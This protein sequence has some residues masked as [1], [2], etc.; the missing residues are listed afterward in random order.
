M[1]AAGRFDLD[2]LERPPLVGFLLGAGRRAMREEGST[3]G[4]LA[5]PRPVE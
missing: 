2:F 5:L 4:A 3:R 1:R